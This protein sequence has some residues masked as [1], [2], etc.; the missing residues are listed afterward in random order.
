MR[1]W[2]QNITID[3][4]YVLMGICFGGLGCLGIEMCVGLPAKT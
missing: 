2:G 4:L 1:A 3:M